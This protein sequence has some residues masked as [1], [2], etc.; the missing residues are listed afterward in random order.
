LLSPNPRFNPILSLLFG[1]GEQWIR[2]CHLYQ[3]LVDVYS[4]RTGVKL[5]VN[6]F[7]RRSRIMKLRNMRDNIVAL[8]ALAIGTLAMA[9]V[10]G[11]DAYA[12][13]AGAEARGVHAL[14]TIMVETICPDQAPTTLAAV[15]TEVAR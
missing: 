13:A 15:S 6:T 10:V 2:D 3:I 9:G 1:I 4:V 7:G 11:S 5:E 8:S 14:S 12:Q